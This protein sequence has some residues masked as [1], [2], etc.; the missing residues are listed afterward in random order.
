V[1]TSGRELALPRFWRD[2]TLPFI[3]ARSVHDGRR[4]RYAKHAHETFSI[5]IVTN[6]RCTYVNWKTRERIGAGSVVVSGPR[7]GIQP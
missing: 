7:S 6:G 2:D 1:V 5:G 3:E 4:V